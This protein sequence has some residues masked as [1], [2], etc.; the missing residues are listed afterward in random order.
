MGKYDAPVCLPNFALLQF[1]IHKFEL[2]QIQNDPSNSYLWMF[3]ILSKIVLQKEKPQ[4]APKRL[5]KSENSF[6]SIK[7]QD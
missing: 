5:E 6:S 7:D 1:Y 4:I 3:E 2:P